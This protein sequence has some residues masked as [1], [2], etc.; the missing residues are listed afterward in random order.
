MHS[1]ARGSSAAEVRPGEAA[2]GAEA[3]N[4]GLRRAVTDLTLD[5][6]I[7]AEARAGKLL[8]PVS[9]GVL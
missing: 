4:R 2:E 1:L 8:V 7:L 6:Q 5:K 9:P 3:E